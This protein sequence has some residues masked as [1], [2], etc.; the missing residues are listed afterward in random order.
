MDNRKPDNLFVPVTPKPACV[1]AVILL[2][3]F[4]LAGCSQATKR[5]EDASGNRGSAQSTQAKPTSLTPTPSSTPEVAPL[6]TPERVAAGEVTESGGGWNRMV[7]RI[8]YLSSAD[9]TRQPMMFYK[10]QRDEPRP[11]LVALHSWSEN[12][13][14]AES[15][16]YAEW[17]IANDWVFIHPNF[18]GANVRPQATGSELVIGDVLSAI[19]YAKA[20]APVDESRVYAVGWSGGGYLGLLLAG[21]A[22]EIW[23]G[24]SAWVPISDLN[25]WYE[26]SRRLGTKYVRQIAASC[27]GSPTGEGAAAEECRKRSALTYL[28]RARGVPLDINHGIR[29]GRNNDDPVPVSQSLRAFNLLAAPQDRFTEEEVAYF[30]R[31]AQ[32]PPALRNETS[33]PSYGGLR[34]LFRRQSGSARITVFDGAHD[35]NTEAAFRWLNRQRRS[36]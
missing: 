30:T 1:R 6:R 7:Q 23:A 8:T 2:V 22:P 15:A 31:E 10:P 19:D 34:I 18:R 27:G 11:L 17:C 3:C 4:A 12:Y 9:N 35:K 14:Q 26:E 16:I 24:V 36:R 20:N 29:D 33:D 5:A 25:A 28:E 13:T 32:V 21:R